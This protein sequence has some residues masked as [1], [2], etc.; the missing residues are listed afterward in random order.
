M[1][2]CIKT[3]SS[4]VGSL[5]VDVKLITN[6]KD[7]ANVPNKQFKSVFNEKISSDLVDMGHSPFESMQDLTSLCLGSANY[8]NHLNP[9]RPQAA[10]P[11]MV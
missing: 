7:K 11:L 1:V 8:S 6:T 9:T 4:G 2:K 10:E 5:K 3:Y